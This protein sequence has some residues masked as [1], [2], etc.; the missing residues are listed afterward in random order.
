M[1]GARVQQRT[2]M[3]L[4]NKDEGTRPMATCTTSRM[5]ALWITWRAP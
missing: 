3:T 1:R 5:A 4:A 2:C